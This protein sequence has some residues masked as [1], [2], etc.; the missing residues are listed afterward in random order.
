MKKIAIL[1]AA[2]LLV[3]AAS[4]TAAQAACTVPYDFVSGTTAVADQVDANFTSLAGCAVP[5]T[6]PSFSGTA[7]L[8]GN[9]SAY[10]ISR[11]ISNGGVGNGYAAVFQL[12]NTN[13]KSGQM[14]MADSG[15]G[16]A[17]YVEPNMLTMSTDSGYGI[18]INSNGTD[19]NGLRIATNGATSCYPSCSNV[20]D[21]R[22]K[23]DIAP[24]AYE[25][26]L[27]AI[28]ALRPVSYRWKDS[29]KGDGQ[30]IGLLAQD[31]RS[32]FPQAVMNTGVVT[33]EAPDGI[34]AVNYSALIAPMVLSIQQLDARTKSV[35]AMGETALSDGRQQA[36]VENFRDDALAL[37]KQL[38]PV[39]FKSRDADEFANGRQIGFVAQEVQI[40]APELVFSRKDKEKTL[41]LKSGSLIPIL[42]KAVQQQQDQIVALKAANETR[43]LEIERLQAQIGVLQR[44]LGVQ[45]AQ[46]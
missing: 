5:S 29:K 18:K 10:A 20:S 36:G 45:T 34:L 42:T 3:I 12:T 37:V 15:G 41:A 16:T 19:N 9:A 25:S 30:Q 23:T 1:P 35:I 17:Y 24:L 40:I 31:V 27:G 8:N 11:V 43:S 39:S 14:Y 46:K 6:N 21:R 4:V 33:K 26:G 7:T 2:V 28:D 32:V 22:I 13:N 38:R 44:K